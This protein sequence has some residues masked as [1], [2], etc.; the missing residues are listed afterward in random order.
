MSGVERIERFT[1]FGG[2]CGVIVAGDGP[3]R[4]ATEAAARARL[5]LLEWHGQF[6]RFEPGS[7]LSRLNADQR[8]WIPVSPLMAYFAATARYAADLTGGLVDATL[9]EEI[10][11]AGYREELPPRLPLELTLALAPRRRT[12]SG[13]PQRRWQAL[14]A[15]TRSASVTRPPGLQLD[16]GGLA[17]GLFADL[18][19]EEL[20][21]HDTFAVDCGGDLSIGGAAGLARP[22]EVQ[23][24]FDQS[25]LHTFELAGTGVATS[26]IGR[27]AWLGAD[28]LPA[29]HLLDPA[30][31][32]PAF[33]GVVQATALAPS[34][35]L[36][37]IHA[38]AAVLSG[39]ADGSRWLRWGGVLV[40]D[41]GSHRVIEPA[42]SRRGSVA[43]PSL[44]AAA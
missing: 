4:S 19:A 18:L 32:R 29:H 3:A 10:R 30:T 7:E 2:T 11:Q 17:K 31:G 20:A 25:V 43:S 26:G 35:V 42:G 23:S 41:D 38:K 24:P 40:L 13:S 36:A 1:C 33:T 34:A 27:R 22:I 15:D 28:G 6:S 12:A 9:L 39:P 5:R 37:E 16:S 44:A 14:E 21:D 8:E